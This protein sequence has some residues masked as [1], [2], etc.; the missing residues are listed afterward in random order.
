M[1]RTSTSKEAQLW[2]SLIET[3][4]KLSDGH[5]TV[6]KIRTNWRV[7]FFTPNLREDIDSM[8]VGKTFVDAARL[9]LENPAVRPQGIG[10]EELWPGSRPRTPK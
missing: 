7:G 4:N 2:N 8:A 10:V 6:M 9:A 5:L 3:A 1:P